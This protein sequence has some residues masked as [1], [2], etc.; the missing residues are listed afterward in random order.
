VRLWSAAGGSLRATLIGHEGEV[1]AVAISPDGAWLAS[2]SADQTMRLWSAAGGSPIA[3]LAGHEGDVLAMAISPD[4]AWLASTGDDG[5]VRLW[6]VPAALPVTALRMDGAVLCCCWYPC[7][8][9]RLAFAGSA[10]F[11]ALRLV[12]PS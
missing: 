2:A 10:G 1:L 4:S 7:G 11:G 8:L 5:T 3:T 9:L 12:L 6:S